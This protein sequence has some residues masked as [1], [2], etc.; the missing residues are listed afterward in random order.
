MTAVVRDARPEALTA[1]LNPIMRWV[2]RTVLGRAV[3]RFGLLE[4]E[5]RRSHRLLRIPVGLH[6]VDGQIVVTPASWRANFADGAPA[7]LHHRGRARAVHGR[8][9]TDPEAVAARLR[10]LLE[11]GTQARDLGFRLPEGHVL[12]AADVVL[13]GR[14]VV[15]LEPA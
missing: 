15:E 4:V 13:L 12:T 9:V 10:T 8:L 7:T 3:P 1:V 2:L 6:Q 5:G 11:R 14:A